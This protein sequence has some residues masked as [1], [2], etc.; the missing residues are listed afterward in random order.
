MQAESLPRLGTTVLYLLF[1]TCVEFFVSAFRSGDFLCILRTRMYLRCTT[2]IPFI[3]NVAELSSRLDAPTM[4]RVHCGATLFISLQA[5]KSSSLL[6]E[7]FLPR[8]LFVY[9]ID[10][11]QAPFSCGDATSA[12]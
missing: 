8:R 9:T 10:C 12:V 2:R 7:S 1:H 6:T 4:W 5:A 11:I 3:G